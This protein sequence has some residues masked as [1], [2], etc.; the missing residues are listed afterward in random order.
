MGFCGIGWR[1]FF[2]FC[3]WLPCN[4]E[5]VVLDLRSR[6]SDAL[7]WSLMFIIMSSKSCEG[8][9]SRMFAGESR[10]TARNEAKGRKEKEQRQKW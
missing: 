7:S 4:W 2:F 6:F 1:T 9:G 3:V 8:G 10:K 5:I